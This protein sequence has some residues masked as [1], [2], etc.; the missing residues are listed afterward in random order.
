MDLIFSTP[1]RGVPID[2]ALAPQRRAGYAAPARGSAVRVDQQ[3]RDLVSLF[4]TPP[5]FVM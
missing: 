1:T 5:F 2:P 3:R 4:G